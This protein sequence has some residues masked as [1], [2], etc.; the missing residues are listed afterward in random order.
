MDHLRKVFTTVVTCVPVLI[1]CAQETGG[2]TELTRSRMP[3]QRSIDILAGGNAGP[4][5]FFELGIARRWDHLGGHHPSTQVVFI[6]AEGRVGP[7]MVFAPKIG[8]WTGGGAAG[9]CLGINALYYLDGSTSA[10]C[11]RPEIGIGFDQFKM[12]YGYH[13][14]AED[15]QRV[16][17][18]MFSLAL[19][20]SLTRD[21]AQP[22]EY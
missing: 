13:I 18:H 14:L 12:A 9:M 16:N 8:A 6:G 7:E 15:I 17:R 2:P 21:E 3:V 5:V 4:Y 1:A 19:L 11:L 10:A 22:V 20:F